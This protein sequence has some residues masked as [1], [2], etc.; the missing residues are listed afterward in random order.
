MIR[1][2]PDRRIISDP[3]RC[4]RLR[5]ARSTSSPAKAT[6]HNSSAAASFPP[7]W[8]ARGHRPL[9][10][11]VKGAGARFRFDQLSQVMTG[12]NLADGNPV[13][14]GSDSAAFEF[15]VR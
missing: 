3:Q 7:P 10:P 13:D 4:M 12:V 11:E 2:P 15:P 9:H 6:S 1:T 14:Y 5:A 8:R